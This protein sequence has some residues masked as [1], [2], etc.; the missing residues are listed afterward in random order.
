MNSTSKKL[1]QAA[2]L[3]AVLVP[4]GSIAV[5][6][7]TINCVSQGSGSCTATY[8]GGGGLQSNIWKFFTDGSFTELIYT[9]EIEAT[10]ITSYDLRVRDVVTTQEALE[11]NGELV[12]FP[13]A[14]CIPT[15]SAGECG[16]FDVFQSDGIADSLTGYKI[17][18]NWFTNTD[19]LSQ[20]PDDG[21]NVILQAKDTATGS[22]RVFTN[23]L[24]ENEYDPAPT[25]T[26]PGLSGR[27]DGFS[28]FGAF[29]GEG[30]NPE[31]NPIPEP[32]TMVLL[33]A[34]V[35]GLISRARM[36]RKRDA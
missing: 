34:G 11:E 24:L 36:K 33:G 27:A 10:P 30:L 23:P 17:S 29:R 12:L 15:Y 25:P 3:T 8:S 16:L 32:G 28:R 26:D 6:T 35:A 2:A 20:P 31:L 4:L 9:F 5:E 13:T 1:L 14:T 18:I 22:G 21:Q 7:A 19:P